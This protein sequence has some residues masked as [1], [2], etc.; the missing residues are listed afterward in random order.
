MTWCRSWM[1]IAHNGSCRILLA[2]SS[3]KL[4]IH[5]LIGHTEASHGPE[6]ENVLCQI[7]FMVKARAACQLTILSPCQRPDTT[8]LL[9]PS[10]SV[11]NMPLSTPSTCSFAL[12]AEE[13]NLAVPDLAHHNVSGCCI[14]RRIRCKSLQRSLKIHFDIGASVHPAKTCVCLPANQRASCEAALLS[15]EMADDADLR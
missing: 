2:P 7:S 5:D 9:L 13:P 14:R 15:R 10:R 12:H 11:C 1:L 3:G 8:C 6:D 4:V